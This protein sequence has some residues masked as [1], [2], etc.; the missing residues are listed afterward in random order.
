V[1]GESIS[2]LDESAKLILIKTIHSRVL[3][4]PALTFLIITPT[5]VKMQFKAT[6]LASLLSATAIA[7]PTAFAEPIGTKPVTWEMKNYTEGRYL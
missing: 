5:N 1:A 4:N 2:S 3:R 7:A 6:I